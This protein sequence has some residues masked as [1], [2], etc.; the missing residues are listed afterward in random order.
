MNDPDPSK[1]YTSA[2]IMEMLRNVEEDTKSEGLIALMFGL[3]IGNCM[4]ASIW[5][6]VYL[7]SPR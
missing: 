1:R 6:L 5:M 2:Q 4:M 7:L 3:F